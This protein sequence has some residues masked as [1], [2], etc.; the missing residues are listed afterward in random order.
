MAGLRLLRVLSIAGLAN[1]LP[2]PVV[3]TDDGPVRGK[4]TDGVQTFH[5]IPFAA[6][7]ALENRFTSPKRPT[8]WTKVKETT[9]AG[10][11]CPQFDFIKGVHVGEEDCLYLSVVSGG[12][13]EYAA[14]VG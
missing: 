8:P 12:L 2:G 13:V 3:Q 11:Q 9:R 7:V 5:G 6:P 4:E 14:A 10:P 1:A